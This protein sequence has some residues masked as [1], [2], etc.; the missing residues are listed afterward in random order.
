MPDR[1]RPHQRFGADGISLARF[2]LPSVRAQ[3]AAAPEVHSNG[4]RS[5]ELTGPRR[6]SAAAVLIP[7]QSGGH[8]PQVRGALI[9]NRGRDHA[10]SSGV[11]ARVPL[12]LSRG[13]TTGHCDAA[14]AVD[15]G[16]DDGDGLNFWRGLACA[17]VLTAGF[18]A[19]GIG[20]LALWP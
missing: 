5:D 12:N 4:A 17:V 7:V 9:E 1:T 20:G 2:D 10:A 14:I 11:N 18:L 13:T 8:A 19:I 6:A 3:G 16:D 15:H